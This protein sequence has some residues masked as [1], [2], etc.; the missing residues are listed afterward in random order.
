MKEQGVAGIRARFRVCSLPTS[1][2]C[3]R[4]SILRS[5]F[6][7]AALAK[8]IPSPQSERDGG[9]SQAEGMLVSGSKEAEEVERRTSQ[10]FLCSEIQVCVCAS[11]SSSDL[12]LSCTFS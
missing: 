5:L 1:K 2:S 6:S 11:S 12:S 9:A 3:F 4:T 7:E 8:G 10:R